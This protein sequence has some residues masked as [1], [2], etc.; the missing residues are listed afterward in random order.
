MSKI[1]N[2]FSLEQT[3]KKFNCSYLSDISIIFKR[4]QS[5]YSKKHRMFFITIFHV[6]WSIAVSTEWQRKTAMIF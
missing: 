4:Y 5:K 1:E 6:S 3:L 2:N